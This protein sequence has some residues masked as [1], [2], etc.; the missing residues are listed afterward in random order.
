[1]RHFEHVREKTKL[2][3]LEFVNKAYGLKTSNKKFPGQMVSVLDAEAVNRFRNHHFD[4]LRLY[5]DEL[6]Q[7]WLPQKSSKTA[8]NAAN[9]HALE[10]Q[11]VEPIYS[12]NLEDTEVHFT[13]HHYQYFAQSITKLISFKVQQDQLGSNN[14]R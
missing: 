1:M 11:I 9:L 2:N 4:D 12:P 7:Q 3:V 14:Y 8:V 6:V 10:E 13:S 5:D